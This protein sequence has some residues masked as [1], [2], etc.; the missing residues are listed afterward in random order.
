MFYYYL[1]LVSKS[2][3]CMFWFSG[4]MMLVIVLGIGVCMIIIM[5]NYLMLV[6]LILE[7]S[8]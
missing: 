6:N 2:I 5:V 4:L 8:D 1:K 3:K 7:K